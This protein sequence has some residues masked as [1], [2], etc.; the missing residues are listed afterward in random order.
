MQ[1]RLDLLLVLLQRL[2][3]EQKSAGTSS[4]HDLSSRKA[5]QLTEAVRTVDDGVQVRH[6]RVSEHEIA[7]C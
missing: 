6:L 7:V 3:S 2:W 1:R 4:L 5:R